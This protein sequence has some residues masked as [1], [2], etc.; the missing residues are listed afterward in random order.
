VVLDGAVWSVSAGG[1]SRQ[2]FPD[3]SGEWYVASVPSRDRTNQPARNTQVILN[4]IFYD[5]PRSLTNAPQF[6]ELFNRGTS[7]VDLSRWRLTEGVEFLMP[8]GTTIAPGGFLVIARAR[9]GCGR[10]MAT[11][12]CWA[13]SRVGCAGAG[14]ACGLWMPSG[15]SSMKW[16]SASGGDWPRLAHGGGSSLE[17]IHPDLD[18]A[19]ASAWRDSLEE[20]KSSWREYS[21]TDT[22]AELSTFGQPTDYRE[23]HLHLVGDGHLALRRI[24]LWRDGTNW[25]EHA[26]RLAADGSSASGW[27]AQG[28]HAAT[29]MTNGE[30]HIVADGHG[31]NRPNRIEIDCPDCAKDGNMNSSS[32]RAGFQGCRV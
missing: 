12:P 19:R 9:R 20:N 18:N 22:Y 23:L 29:F 6:I 26:D 7:A 30:L 27:L 14:N 13:I 1:E 17:L 31:D 11:F 32:R 24:G 25:L 3:G 28:N 21:F 2:A 10:S 8:S 5:P 4:E 16:I 15:T